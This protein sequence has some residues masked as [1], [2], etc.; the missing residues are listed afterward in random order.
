[1]NILE[2][3]FDCDGTPVTVSTVQ[4][5]GESLSAFAARHRQRVDAA[6]MDCAGDP[7]PPNEIVTTWKAR[8]GTMNY[9]SS[10]AYGQAKHDADVKVLKQVFPEL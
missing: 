5:P 4:N 1:M 8:L 2:T 10:E 6:K 9:S 7:I 3:T